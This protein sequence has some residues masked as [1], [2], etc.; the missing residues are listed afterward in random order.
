MEEVERKLRGMELRMDRREREK[1]KKNVLVR[2]VR[3]GEGMSWEREI[4][5]IWSRMGVEGGIKGMREIGG[6]NREGRG[7]V[8]VE[9]EDREKK[10]EVMKAKAK[11]RGERERL[12]DDLTQME[13]KAR[14]CVERKAEEER[15]KGRRVR[16]G[17]MKMWV[18]NELRVWDEAEEKWW[19]ASG[20][21]EEKG[22]KER[23]RQS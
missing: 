8:L 6:V 12:E 20:D 14:W 21:E 9:L 16:V 17:Y 10:I 4:G 18:D 11:M 1:R 15:R 22:G 5:R 13:R 19:T 2:E 7:M 23:D 3:R